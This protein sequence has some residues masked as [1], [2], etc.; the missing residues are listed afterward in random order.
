MHFHCVDGGV[1]KV[2]IRADEWGGRNLARR[3]RA[4]ISGNGV[5]ERGVLEVGALGEVKIGI[6]LLGRIIVG[7]I[8]H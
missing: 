2:E 5:K 1:S 4:S 8:N 3:L 6:V 7:I